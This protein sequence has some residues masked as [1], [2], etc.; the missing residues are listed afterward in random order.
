[1]AKETLVRP[2]PQDPKGVR[3]TRQTNA[4]RRIVRDNDVKN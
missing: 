1:M 3:D 4:D 2:T